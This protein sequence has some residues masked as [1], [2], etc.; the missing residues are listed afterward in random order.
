MKTTLE[1]CIDSVASAMAAQQG[2]ADRVEL[3]DNLVEGGTTPSYGMIQRV[4][5]RCNLDLMVIIRP[6]GGDFLFDEDEK[7]VMLEDIAMV[8]K[9]GV[10]GVVIGALTSDAEIDVEMTR[11]L[12]AAA[13]GMDVTFHRA[14][15]MVRDQSEALETLIE[16]GVKR[17]LTSG[18]AATVPEGVDQI[19]SLVEQANGR[20][21]LM[22]GGGVKLNNAREVVDHTGVKQMHT[23]ASEKTQ[24]SMGYQNTQC[25]MGAASEGAE[26]ERKLANAD[27][28]KSIV[29]RL[30]E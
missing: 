19:K 8:K 9:L 23:T 1:I 3:C 4:K 13:D 28:I 16:I 24:S 27:L 26:Y 6:R 10:D 11:E 12:L 15:D 25:Y 30:A 2:G 20:I 18:G 5:Q 14:F 7:Q 22:P 29:S 17:V 21:E